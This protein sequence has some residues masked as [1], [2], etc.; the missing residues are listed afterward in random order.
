MENS[1]MC[2]QLFSLNAE[3]HVDKLGTGHVSCSYV[4]RLDGMSLLIRDESHDSLLLV[5][6]IQRDIDYRKRKTLIAWSDRTNVNFLLSFRYKIGCDDIYEQICKVKSGCHLPPCELGKLDEINY[7]ISNSLSSVI[8]EGKKNSNVLNK[9]YRIIK[10]VVALN[11]LALL[12][13]MFSDRTILDVVGCLEYDT[14]S[15]G[16]KNHREYLRKVSK[17]REVIPIANP[18]LLSKIHQTYRVQYIH[19]VILPIFSMDKTKKCAMSAFIFFNKVEVVNMVKK[20]EFLTPLFVQL[21]DKSTEVNKRRDLLLFLQELCNLS[22]VL[23]R[24]ARDYF[25]TVLLVDHGILTA[26]EI[27]LGLDLDDTTKSACFDILSQFVEFNPVFARKF[28]LERNNQ[29]L[30]NSVIRHLSMDGAVQIL[31]LLIE[32]KNMIPE[33]MTGFLNFFYANSVHVLIAPLLAYTIDD[34]YEVVELLSVVLKV[35][36]F[37]VVSHNF[38]ITR[39]IVKEDLLRSVLLL[40]KSKH[41]FLVLE[42]LKLM[43]R[44]IGVQDDD[45]YRYIMRGNLF[46]P[47]VDAFERNNGRYNLLDSAIIEMFEFIRVKNIKSLRVHLMLKFG[48]VF[49]KVQ[50]VQTFEKM[51]IHQQNRF[52]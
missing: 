40:L 28:I 5:S 8:F 30:I 2:V 26:L 42:A 24:P 4:E 9:F 18:D 36:D 37:C 41:K 6:K 17:F 50:Y 32:P 43:R 21:K 48:K 11:N 13:A 15:V 39:F 46:H 27:T 34:C 23:N 10:N 35:L 47:V 31:K 52:K 33:E 49:D 44:I 16:S 45:Y 22:Y 3:K 51:K 25:F 14:C 12:R 19:D 38:R 1:Q 29:V 7:V 20:D